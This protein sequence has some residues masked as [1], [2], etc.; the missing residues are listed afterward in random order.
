MLKDLL[1]T[2]ITVS[3]NSSKTIEKT[4]QSVLDQTYN[5]YE[6]IIIDGNS[7]D[8]TINM[9]R[10][11][12]PLFNGKMRWISESDNGIYNAMNKG[13]KMAKGHFV[14]LVNSDD[15]LEKNALKILANRIATL[16]D[17]NM[18]LLCGWMNFHYLDGTVQ[19]LTTDSRRFNNHIKNYKIGIRH[20]ATFV[21]IDTYYTIGFFDEV[22]KIA[23][24]FDFVIRCYRNRCKFIFIDEV[25][26]NMSDGGVSNKTLSQSK[27]DCKYVLQKHTTNKFEFWYHYTYWLVVRNVK[28]IT[29]LT[30]LKKIR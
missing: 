19:L 30:I 23:A 15:W 21:S 5:N 4:I 16:K 25:I 17:I 1:F 26:T 28:K 11:Y 7:T 20:P 6:Y 9:I 12:E 14:G 2:I 18:T 29:P 10:K 22:L 27:M 3:Y 8:G 24:D 13:I